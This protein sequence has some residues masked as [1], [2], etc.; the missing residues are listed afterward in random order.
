L[1]NRQEYANL[2]LRAFSGS[3]RV[4]QPVTRSDGYFA[5][6]RSWGSFRRH[7]HS[8]PFHRSISLRV[9]PPPAGSC[10]SGFHIPKL[11]RSQRGAPITSSTPNLS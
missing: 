9:T 5:L 4:G 1:S 10:Y 2:D 7:S 11:R 6:H 3:A 8:M